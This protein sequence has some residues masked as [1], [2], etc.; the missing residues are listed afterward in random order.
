VLQVFL[1]FLFGNVEWDM[2]MMSCT[3][4]LIVSAIFGPSISKQQFRKI[5]HEGS[6]DG[7]LS[8]LKKHPIL[9]LSYG[10]IIFIS[11]MI[12]V[13]WSAYRQ[14]LMEWITGLFS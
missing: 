9:L 11:L 5:F 14:Q 8:K 1:S 13:D 3:C 4:V 7:F 6:S 2:I 12:L 10:T